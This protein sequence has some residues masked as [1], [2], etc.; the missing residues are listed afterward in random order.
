MQTNNATAFA[1]CR[2]QNRQLDLQRIAIL[3]AI[4]VVSRRLAGRLAKMEHQAKS[5][6][7]NPS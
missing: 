7:R 5:Q 6:R 3:T 4:S 2:E 1:D